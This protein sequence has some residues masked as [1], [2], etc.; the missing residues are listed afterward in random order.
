MKK[1]VVTA[2]AVAVASWA[3]APAFAQQR[4]FG[5][6]TTSPLSLLSQKSV[7]EELKMTEDQVKKGTELA[8]KMRGNRQDFQNLSREEIQKKLAE[9]AEASE[10]AMAE[11]LKPEQV[12]RL[13]QIALQQQ[14]ARALATEKVADGVKLSA[15]QKEKVKGIMDEYNTALR[16]A[17][18]GGFND[19]TRKK[20]EELRKSTDE[21]LTGV[22][23]AEQKAAWTKLTGEPF[24]GEIVRTRRP[25]NN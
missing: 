1:F 10:K 12:T 14:G 18:Q 23:S 22:L 2:I 24:K 20:M 13:N 8:E 25:N 19:E 11:F 16:A 9:R 3:A 15:E 7:Q 17:F 4:G 21:K 6:F 5:G